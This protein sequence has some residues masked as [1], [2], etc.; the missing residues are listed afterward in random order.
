MQHSVEQGKNMHRIMQPSGLLHLASK[1]PHEGHVTAA[2]AVIGWI[3]IR[4]DIDII[5]YQQE[6]MVAMFKGL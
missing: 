5:V 4:P 1:M 2:T 3:H 6:K